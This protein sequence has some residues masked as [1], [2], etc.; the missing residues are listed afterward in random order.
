M[1]PV[2]RIVI[3]G[4]GVGG[5]L[6]ANLLAK[7]LRRQI[8]KGAV[9][10]IV[11]D[12]TGKH[13]YQPG[14][15]YIAMG[16]ERAER[17]ERAERSLLD[18]RVSLVVGEIDR[19]DTAHQRLHVSTG[20]ELGYDPVRRDLVAATDLPRCANAGIA[21]CNWIPPRPGA[22]CLSCR[23]TRTR[24][25]D[26]DT[27]AMAA[28]AETEA[29][30]R[31]LV[32]QPSRLEVVEGWTRDPSMWVRRAALVAALP[33]AKLT[34]PDAAERASRERVLGWAESYVPDRDWFIQ[35]A[36]AWWLRT[37]GAHDP[38]RVRRFLDGP[39][40]GLKS[41]ARKDAARRLG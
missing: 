6:T 29:A 38:E 31:R 17:L 24:P 11:V 14:F 25:A 4:G 28:F 3:L 41:F 33:W 5:T 13:V 32:A 34:H 39:G 21:A 9:E 2:K 37:L 19:V 8:D 10:L 26:A 30:K 35:K 20:Q 12:A 40:Q 23:L 18:D 15:M 22:L 27:D 36:V 16:G 1:T 7:R